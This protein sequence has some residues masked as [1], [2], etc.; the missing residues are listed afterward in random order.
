[1]GIRNYLIEGGSGTGKT[2][3]AEELERRGHHVVHGDRT[4]AYYGDPDTGEPMRTPEFADE[5]DTVR[6]GLDHWIWPVETVRTLIAD[7]TSAI[8]FFCGHSANAAQFTSL[9]DAVFLLDVDAQT[10]RTRLMK[11]PEDEFGGKPIERDVVLSL[12]QTQDDL[13]GH[14][15]RIDAT[16]PIT[17]V[18]DD[19]LSRLSGG[20][21]RIG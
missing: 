10:L 9:F 11:R 2:T 20:D 19:I 6:W 17:R 8:T 16:A 21:P 4:L 1:M 7:H 15:V 13:A 5:A 12:H 14:A 3:V 18:V